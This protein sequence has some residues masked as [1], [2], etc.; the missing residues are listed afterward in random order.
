MIMMLKSIYLIY[1]ELVCFIILFLKLQFEWVHFCVLSKKLFWDENVWLCFSGLVI[2][3]EDQVAREGSW[4]LGMQGAH[5]W[6]LL[7]CSLN[8]KL[9]TLLTSSGLSPCKNYIRNKQ[10]KWTNN[11]ANGFWTI[12]EKPNSDQPRVVWNVFVCVVF[13]W[14]L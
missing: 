10:T 5:Y 8:L 14:E 9:P 13:V 11:S 6:D 4:E 1:P 12:Y 7:L 3:A 2:M